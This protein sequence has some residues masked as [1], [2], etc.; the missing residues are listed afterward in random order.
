MAILTETNLGFVLQTNIL[1]F[2]GN[3]VST[4]YN[5]SGAYMP[6]FQKKEVGS[7]GQRIQLAPLAG[8]HASK[9][10]DC[11]QCHHFSLDRH[12]WLAASPVHKVSV[13]TSTATCHSSGFLPIQSVRWPS[14]KLSLLASLPSLSSF[15][16]PI[17]LLLIIKKTN[18]SLPRPSPYPTLL[19]V[20][21]MK[22]SMCAALLHASA[23]D[24]RDGALLLC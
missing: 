7:V 6:A 18:L 16:Q 14:L 24:H 21:L 4:K 13:F 19:W 11:S 23:N 17:S 2:S 20:K 22:V 9:A 10:L 3:F 5:L 12:K 15:F 1:S 8:Q